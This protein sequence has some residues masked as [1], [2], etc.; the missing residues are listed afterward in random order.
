MTAVDVVQ[1]LLLLLGALGL[2]LAVS[3]AGLPVLGG[4]A[5]L[6]VGG[7]GTALLG[8]GGQGWP[9]GLAVLGSVAAG[10]AV[11]Y[12][13]ALGASRLDGPPLALATWA[14]AWLVQRLLL[15]YPDTFGGV[16]GLT[17]PAP[18]HLVTRTLGLDL[19]L[20]PA[21]LVI[22]TGALC[23]LA[24]AALARAAS[25]PG[26]L[27]LAALRE[28]PEIAAMLGVPVARRRRAV[29]ALSGAVLAVAGAGKLLLLGLVVPSD[30]SPLVSLQLFVAVLLGGTARWWGPVVG[31]AVV[32]SLPPVADAV[33]RAA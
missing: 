16:D 11:G 28:G 24:M 20:S 21:A 15:A 26:G 25:G 10:T 30:V 29:L 18:S 5:F 9:L 32:A 13:V 1:L 33:A 22:I 6:A 8:P 2:S 3:W 7:Y 27:D 14:L 12:L 4:G 17:R 19:T 31:V 23:L